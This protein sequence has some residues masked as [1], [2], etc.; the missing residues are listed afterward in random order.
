MK[1]FIFA[2]LLTRAV[3]GQEHLNRPRY[4]RLPAFEVSDDDSMKQ[5]EK[6]NQDHVSLF[7]V[8][9]EIRDFCS[10]FLRCTYKNSNC[11][12]R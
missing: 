1:Q 12:V 6:E 5:E 7:E 10:D 11:C 3:K 9:M 4:A 8:R 2:M